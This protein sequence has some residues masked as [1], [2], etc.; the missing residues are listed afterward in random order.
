MLEV[1]RQNPTHGTCAGV[2]FRCGLD[3]TVVLGGVA[4]FGGFGVHEG[5]GE[6]GVH[7]VL[8]L[9]VSTDDRFD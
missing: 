9:V 1:S 7:G 2:A 3:E 6:A 8:L 5:S 4:N